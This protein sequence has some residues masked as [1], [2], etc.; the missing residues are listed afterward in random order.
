MFKCIA[1]VTNIMFRVV[2]SQDISILTM[3][4]KS[5]NSVNL[6]LAFL[7]QCIISSVQR[8]TNAIDDYS[9]NT[10]RRTKRKN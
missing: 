10:R 1:N 2:I 7:N 4:L 9:V 6:V 5:T 3:H 8:T